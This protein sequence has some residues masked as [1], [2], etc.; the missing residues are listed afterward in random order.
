[1]GEGERLEP[2]IVMRWQVKQKLTPRLSDTALS[3]P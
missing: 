3:E 1:M 2:L